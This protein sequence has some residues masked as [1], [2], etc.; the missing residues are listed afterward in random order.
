MSLAFLII[1]IILAIVIWTIRTQAIVK[2]GE[3]GQPQ[4]IFL[5]VI[6]IAFLLAF[7]FGLDWQQ[8]QFDPETPPFIDGGLNLSPEFATI[9]FG[10]SFYTAAFIAEVVR[11]GIQSVNKG[12]WEAAR[13]LGLKPSLVMYLVIF[14]QALRV[15]IPPLTSEYLNLAKNSSLATAIGYFD[16]YAVSN[17][18]ANQSGRSIEMLLIVMGSYLTL[19]L[20]ISLAMNLLNFAVKIKER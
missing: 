9:L 2:R 14:P 18:I 5:M 3:S 4:L 1:S 19:N 15:M 13:A 6:A 20:I 17:T 12:Q 11:A 16:I 10:V 7:I 8:P